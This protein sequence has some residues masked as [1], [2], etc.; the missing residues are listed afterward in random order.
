VYLLSTL[1]GDRFRD[2]FA[3]F[4]DIAATTLYRREIDDHDNSEPA[5]SVLKRVLGPL[6]TTLHDSLLRYISPSDLIDF[7]DGDIG[8]G[9]FGAVSAATWHRKRSLDFKESWDVPVVLKR[10]QEM[11][12]NAALMDLFTREV[13]LRPT[14]GNL[15]C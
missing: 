11:P 12:S 10:L 13:C 4:D 9:S 15:E 1:P 2:T 5:N 14:R 6:H 8:K 7:G 3:A